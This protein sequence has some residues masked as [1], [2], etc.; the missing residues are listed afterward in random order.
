MVHLNGRLPYGL[1]VVCFEAEA[2]GRRALYGFDRV[3]YR[4]GW[5]IDPREYFCLMLDGQR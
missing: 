3:G 2:G 4:E 5:E 1:R